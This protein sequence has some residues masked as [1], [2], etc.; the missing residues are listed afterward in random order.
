MEVVMKLFFTNFGI[1]CNMLLFSST[2]FASSMINTDCFWQLNCPLLDSIP[3]MFT[4]EEENS[5]FADLNSFG[6]FQYDGTTFHSL[7]VFSGKDKP[8]TT[9]EISCGTLSSN[10]FERYF[11]FFGFYLDTRERGTQ[12]GIFSSDNQVGFGTSDRNHMLT[13]LDGMVTYGPP[14]NYGERPSYSLYFEE[15]KDFDQAD[16][17]DFNDMVITMSGMD[18]SGAMISYGGN[19]APVPGTLFLL[20]GGIPFVLKKRR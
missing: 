15:L 9:R 6:I 8:G 3:V 18:P 14:N 20:A 11:P 7:E 4:L 2:V 13:F 5:S 12:G 1:I 16:E 19:P 17:P 10:G